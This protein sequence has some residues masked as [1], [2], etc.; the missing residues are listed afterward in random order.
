[1]YKERI[2]VRDYLQAEIQAAASSVSVVVPRSRRAVE[3]EVP[4]VSV[5]WYHA[6]MAAAKLENRQQFR[7]AK[8]AGHTPKGYPEVGIIAFSKREVDAQQEQFGGVHAVIYAL[9]STVMVGAKEEQEIFHE[10]DDDPGYYQVAMGIGKKALIASAGLW[11]PDS[12][13]LWSPTAFIEQRGIHPVSSI[14]PGVA[15]V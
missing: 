3:P 7:G 10:L 5:R 9:G 11:S 6:R 2:R 4:H 1:M 8:D 12:R 14:T 13:T 15:Y